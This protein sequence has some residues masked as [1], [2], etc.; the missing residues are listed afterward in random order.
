[1]PVWAGE[2]WSVVVAADGRTVRD[3]VRLGVDAD[4]RLGGEQVEL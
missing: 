4:G 1:V 2:G 3:G